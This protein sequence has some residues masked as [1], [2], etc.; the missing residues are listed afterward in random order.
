MRLRWTVPAVSSGQRPERQS[1]RALDLLTPREREVMGLV[2][3][4]LLNKQ[5]AAKLNLQRD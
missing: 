5:I 1:S 2:T 4:G 3:A